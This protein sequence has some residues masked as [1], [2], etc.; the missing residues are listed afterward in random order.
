MS[1]VRVKVISINAVK[2]GDEM[3]KKITLSI[4]LTSSLLF[5]S[6]C[7]FAIGVNNGHLEVCGS[8]PNC[9]STTNTEAPHAIEPWSYDSASNLDDI[10]SRLVKLL[11]DNNAEIITVENNY[12]HAE[13]KSKIFK[14]VDDVEFLI[15]ENKQ[16]IEV[17]SASRKGYFDFKVNLKRVQ[18]LKKSYL[19]E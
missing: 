7:I 10:K 19:A 3:L 9:V 6:N 18:K 17:R 4:L 12:I 13:F 16:S 5:N 14:F 2:K 1:I 8:K 15:D 11:D